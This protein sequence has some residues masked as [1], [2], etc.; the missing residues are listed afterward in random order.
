MPLYSYLARSAAGTVR[1]GT[2]DAL[3][4]VAAAGRLEANGLLPIEIRLRETRG[5]ELRAL[6]LRAGIGRPTTKDLVLLTRQLYTI[7][8]AGLPWLRGLRSL[9]STTR[10][11]ALRAALEQAAASLE[12]G[13]DL[14]SSFADCG[15]TFPPLYVA[16]VRV[17]EQSGTLETVFARLADYLQAQQDLRDRVK[18]AMRYPAIVIATIAVA[19]AVLSIVVIPKFAPMFKQLGGQLPWPTQVLLAT[20]SFAQQHWAGL[21]GALAGM[22]VAFA[23]ATRR[24]PG[25]FWWHRLRLRLPIFGHLQLEAALA[26]TMRTLSLTLSA[27]LPMIEALQLVARAVDNDFLT[28]KIES[29]RTQLETGEPLSAAA[30]QTGIIPPLLLQMIEVGE[31]TGEL[32]RLLDEVADHYRREVDYRLLNLTATIEPLLISIVGGMVLVLALGI[33]LPLWEMIAQAAR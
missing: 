4:P 22:I 28:Q 1:H 25:R 13:R 30:A 10:H 5:L 27:G 19:L 11:P 32:P 8:K 3:D 17:G 15:A 14:S 20:S 23:L 26:R 7:A 2:I 33:F 21:I 18:G 31:E 16:M 6:L 12:S 9:A 29:M 24:G